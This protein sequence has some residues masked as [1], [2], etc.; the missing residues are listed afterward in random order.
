MSDYNK[1][2]TFDSKEEYMK[3]SRDPLGWYSK[4]KDKFKPL[5]NPARKKDKKEKEC[6]QKTK[7]TEEHV[8]KEVGSSSLLFSKI[9]VYENN[10]VTK[11][12]EELRRDME[13]REVSRSIFGAGRYDKA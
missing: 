12:F 8:D 1:S 9:K 3:F 4:N 11:L 5:P 2:Y 6:S 7:K 13:E 10:K